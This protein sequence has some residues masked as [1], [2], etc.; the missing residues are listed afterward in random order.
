MGASA[1]FINVLELLKVNEFPA[2][3][4]ME[5]VEALQTGVFTNVPVNTFPLKSL[6]VVPLPSSKR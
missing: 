6:A 3:G 2:E 4:R 5:A 1:I